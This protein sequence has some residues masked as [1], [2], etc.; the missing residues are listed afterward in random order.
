MDY[1]EG[2]MVRDPVTGKYRRV[3]LFVLTLGVFAESGAAVDVAIQR[4]DLG[5]AARA[6]LST[7]RRDGIVI[8]LDNLAEGVLTPDIYDPALNPVRCV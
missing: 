4:P 7:T 1:G 5:R 2:P 8:I 3:R 6:R